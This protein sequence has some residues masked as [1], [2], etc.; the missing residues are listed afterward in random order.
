MEYPMT[1]N[2]FE[3]LPALRHFPQDGLL[4]LMERGRP[5]T[6]PAERALMRQG[7]PGDTMHVIVKGRVRVERSH[8]S[9]A[10]PL[11]L[12][13]LGP[14]EIVGEMAILNADVRSATVTAVE[15]TETLEVGAVQVL[16]AVHQVPGLGSALLA[17]LSGRLRTTDEL[18]E[19]ALQRANHQYE[20]IIGSLDEGVC[21][22][23]VEGRVILA[24]P[25]VTRLT[26]YTAEELI[27]QNLHGLI[28]HSKPD[29]TPYPEAECPVYAAL[30]DGSDHRGTDEVYW[31][32]NGSS[33]PVEYV[34]IPLREGSQITG[35]V[36]AFQD[37]GQRRAVEQV[38]DEFISLVSHELRTPLTSIRGSLGLLAAGQMG[39][40]PEGAERMLQIAVNNTDRLVRLINDLLDIE[41]M[42]SGKVTMEKA[43]CEIEELATQAV[44]GVRSVAEHAGI[45]LS[46]NLEPARL[47]ADP[48][49]MIQ[50]LTN[51]LGNAIKFSPE[52]S[53]VWLTNRLE[54][55]N[56][57]FQVRDEG[58]GIPS[59]QLENVFERFQQVDASDARQKGGSGL[60]LAICRSIVSQHGGRIWVESVLGQ[61]STFSFTIPMVK[62]PVAE[63]TVPTAPVVF[64]S[65]DDPTILEVVRTLLAQQGYRA[66]IV[67]SPQEVLEQV[68]VEPPA[69]II[70]DVMLP[71]V[72][73][74]EILSVLKERPETRDIPVI[75]F[76]V[77]VSSDIPPRSI[78]GEPAG[79]P[80]GTL[81][82]P[83]LV[84]Q[85]L[86]R[87]S[88]AGRVLIVED[89]V[90]L[91]QVL[92]ATFERD[93]L[94]TF[95]AH[96][97]KEAIQLTQHV[98]PNLLVL[99]LVLPEG[100]GYAVV[101]WL[102]QHDQLRSLPLVVYTAKDLTD[103]ERERLRLGQT[104][105]LVKGRAGPRDVEQHIT[106]LL[107]QIL[108]G[109]KQP[110][111]NGSPEG[112]D[113]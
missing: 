98:M 81:S 78:S 53:S 62:A 51:L 1:S 99:D 43:L 55:D 38:K 73:G 77:L 71:D 83:Q 33:F 65:D 101:D 106:R 105:F 36:V 113:R 19:A 85:T 100:D 13:E 59:D 86:K 80:P 93:G 50:T 96:T 70:L 26:G 47:W 6:Y 10:R 97:G 79:T 15:D 72:K 54:G 48:D 103:A 42:E 5:R 107:D 45:T 90:D 18:L 27:G 112:P 32:K 7:D 11:L 35:A 74:W 102:R 40:L 94:E 29:R 14:G 34:S 92:R 60:G 25:A 16:E 24:N 66:A 110:K 75:S 56:V 31:H 46:V 39:E 88:R 17:L 95:H 28:H 49:R 4:A 44:E 9:L 69:A 108:L 111:T 91:A 3:Q 12:A 22:L 23:D 84:S 104:V 61:G 76:S 89:D 52:G 57:V 63:I 30:H 58:R 64:V 41:R 87:D 21:H 82:W 8:P 2:I 20:L 67:S 68:I 109:R 37:I